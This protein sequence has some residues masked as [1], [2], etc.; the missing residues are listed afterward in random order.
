M[1]CVLSEK[2]D[3]S[4]PSQL[5]GGSIVGIRAISFKE[6]MRRAG[7]GMKLGVLACRAEILFEFLDAGCRDVIVALRV[8]KLERRL[9]LGI[10]AVARRAK[11]NRRGN[12]IRL[13]LGEPER[14]IAA[15]RKSDDADAAF[16]CAAQRAQI[17]RRRDDLFRDRF[18][19]EFRPEFLRFGNRGRGR[20]VI[21]VRREYGEP[22]F[23]QPVAKIFEERIQAS[24]GVQ[25]QD[26]LAFSGFGL[27]EVVFVPSWIDGFAFFG[28]MCVT[29]SR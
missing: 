7:I 15:Q 9:A 13:L 21:E 16:A 28:L 19:F 18:L 10:V 23:R 3:R 29:S 4:F 1:L 12:Q 24:P 11:R 22:L 5:R 17:L 26:A 6:P 27:G 8:M 20:A 25:N 14:P 2:R